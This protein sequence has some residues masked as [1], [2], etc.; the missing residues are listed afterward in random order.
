MGKV[1]TRFNFQERKLNI[2]DLWLAL[3]CVKIKMK[4]WFSNYRKSAHRAPSPSGAR[5]ATRPQRITWRNRVI[6]RFAIWHFLLVAHW[7]RVSLQPFWT[8]SSATRANERTHAN[9]PFSQPANKDDGSQY[10]LAHVIRLVI[11]G[12]V[13]ETA[14]GK[15][16][17]PSRGGV[18]FNF[19]LPYWLVTSSF[20]P[21]LY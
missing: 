4:N 12:A 17:G 6:I 20:P 3:N 9:K 1:L 7:N 21:A 8:Y 16:L 10:L 11:A 5:Y 15:G 19:A 18:I 2:N 13:V 14:P